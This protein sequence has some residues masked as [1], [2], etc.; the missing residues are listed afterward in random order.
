MSHDDFFHHWEKNDGPLVRP[1]KEK[2]GFLAYTLVCPRCPC[3]YQAERDRMI[4]KEV[5]VHPT[6]SLS[7]TASPIGPE[8][9]GGNMPLEYDGAAI[10]EVDGLAVLTACS[11][12]NITVMPCHCR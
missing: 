11:R 7:S 2:H 5:Q 10:I 8:M 12:R 3:H 6:Q 1:W 4:N 9:P